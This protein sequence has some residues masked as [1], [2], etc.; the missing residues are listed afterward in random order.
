MKNW[1]EKAHNGR[2]GVRPTYGP[3]A[4][5]IN[6]VLHARVDKIDS[7]PAEHN[8][9][10]PNQITAENAKFLERSMTI[11]DWLLIHLN[12]PLN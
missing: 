1:N 5:R 8:Q 11:S 12:A 6:N 10:H 9:K 4:N 2:G 3:E 7:M